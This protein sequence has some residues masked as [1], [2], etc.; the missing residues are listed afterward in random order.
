MAFTAADAEDTE[1]TQRRTISNNKSEISHL[2]S[3]IWNLKS[4][5][6]NFLF[7][8][9]PSAFSASAAVNL[10]FTATQLDIALDNFTSLGSE[11]DAARFPDSIVREI[12]LDN[13]VTKQR[14]DASAHEE[15]AGVAVPIHA[16][17][18]TIVVG[19]PSGFAAESPISVKRNESLRRNRIDA[20]S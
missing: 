11:V 16:G 14:E 12:A 13:L 7:L 19:S 5:L 4:A 8:C 1:I 15:R 9:A 20:D 3:Q 18:A 2:E 10:Y 6:S 17:S